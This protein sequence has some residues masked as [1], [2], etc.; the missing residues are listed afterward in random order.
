MAEGRAPIKI[1]TGYIE[2]TPKVLQK[3]IDELRKKLLGEMAKL[4]TSAGKEISKGVQEGIATLPKEVAK[5]AKK[6]K[7]AVEKE[8]LD[9]KK[10]LKRL[11]KELTK[12]FGEETAKRFKDFRKQELKKQKLI[13]ETS[14]ET[15]KAL[16]DAVRL[17]E[18]ANK[19][20]LTSAERLEK[21][22]LKLQEENRKAHE[23]A[24]RDKTKEEA[25]QLKLRESAEREARKRQAAAQREALRQQ[26][27]AQREATRQ[28]VA[29]IRRIAAADRAAA[30]D[31]I[32]AAQLR[33]TQLRDQMQTMRRQTATTTTTTQTYFRRT[34]TSLKNMGTWFDTVGTSISEAGNILT[35]KFLAPLALAGTALTALGVGNAD[36]RLLGQLGLSASGVSK[37][38][39]ADQMKAIQNYAIDTPFSIDV[40]HEYQMKLIRSVAGSDKDWFKGGDKRTNAANNAAVKTTD[41]IMSI[42]DSMARAGNLN[43]TQFQRAMYAMDMIMDMDRAPTRSVK[44]LAAASGMPASELANLLGFKDSQEMWKVIGTPAFQGTKTKK[45][46]VTGTEIMN[47]M[48]NF[49]NPD[50]YP[51][52]QTGDGS[53]GFASKMTSQTITGRLQQMKERS[54]FELGNLFVKEGKGGQYNYTDLGQK[55][56]GKQ[57]PVYGEDRK[58][59]Q[60]VTGYRNEGGILN[61]VTD[62]AKKYSPSIEKFLKLFLDSLSKFIKM[63]DSV[64]NFFKEHPVFT[65]LATSIGQFLVKW[66]PLIVAVGLLSKV[67]GKSIGLVGKLLSPAAA[68]TRGA[69]NAGRGTGRLVGQARAG[70]AARREALANGASRSDARQAGRDA[71]RDRRTQNRA[72]DTRG[73]GRRALDGFMGEDSNVRDQQRQLRELEAEFRQARDEATR[74]RTELRDINRESLRQIADAL[75]GNGANSVQGAANQAQQN[76]NQAQT[77]AQQLNRTNL[78][79]VGNAL[80]GVKDHADEVVKALKDAAAEVKTLDGRKLGS[81]R[82]QQVET[83]SKRVVEL[84]KAVNETSDAVHTLNGKSL[85]AL[86]DHFQQL[87]NAAK[88]STKE[89]KNANSAVNTLKSKS[90]KALRDWFDKVTKAA[91]E[92]YKKVGTRTGTGSLNGRVKSLADQS[93]KKLYDAVNKLA[94]NLEKAKKEAQS[95]DT[96]LD[97]IGKKSPG[98]SGSGGKKPK[99]RKPARGGIINANGLLTR[100]TGGVVPGYQPWVDS[101]PAILSP[102][103]AVLRP[104]VTNHLGEDQINAWNAM[105]VR[106]QLSRHARGGVAGGR[107]RFNLDS[108]KELVDLQNIY[109]VGISAFR[110]MSMDSA[111]DRLGGSSQ[112]GVLRTGDGTSRF[113]G[114]SAADK[115]R[116]MYDWMTEDIW[117]QLKKLPTVVGQVAGALAGAVSPVQGEYFWNDVWKGNGNILDR[118]KTYLGDMFSTKTLGKVWDNLTSGLWDSAKSLWD[119]GKGLLTDPVGMVSGAVGDVYD[120]VK[121][122]YNNLVGMV[123]TVKEFMDSPKDYAGRV[124]NEFMTTA[125]ESMPNTKG[126]FDFSSGSRVNTKSPDM[127]ATMASIPVKGGKGAEKWRLVASQAMSMLGLPP[128]ALSTVLYR[129]QMESGG[130]PNIVNKWDS[131]WKAGHPSVGLMQ[132]IGPTYGAYAG[133]FK[134]TGPKLYG[135]STNPLANIYAGLNYARNRY[136]ARWQSVLAGKT[137]YATGTMS[138][139]PGLA[140]VGEKGRELVAFGGGERVFNNTDTEGLLNGKKYEIHIHEARNEPTPQA[141]LRAL[142]TA[143]ALYTHL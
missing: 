92:A 17:E 131:N 1:G 25:R 121:G 59:N 123:D 15:K 67:L 132:V 35:T 133:P 32:A 37:Q 122:S 12:E 129:I 120:T 63:I 10:T 141:V 50:K 73:A 81:L 52:T 112:N 79:T 87:T 47:A 42:G 85:S 83:T 65:Q 102:G 115:F 40:M 117:T 70:S 108:I 5:Q 45:A 3:D 49:W 97:S 74:L 95:L 103:E 118:G 107:G 100:A 23:R 66:G 8:G 113:L 114:G 128:S 61:Q 140:M 88:E 124:F 60:V 21:N 41:L 127:D 89:I 134:G 33:M 143:E 18:K 72:G 20:R 104:E 43:P 96:S 71:Y 75:A 53:V 137:G 4:G 2:I 119:T 56:M 142:Q 86:R 28:Q 7:E 82:A 116:G 80:Q 109:P 44:Q 14:S 38:T 105:A 34:E 58:G 36:K 64:A 27:A 69:V 9:T 101:V 111:S 48:L 91:N 11:E 126:L 39:S 98:S 94:T 24:E 68:V 110:T 31:G 78:T 29:E 125:Q 77:Q 55:I 76:L 99:P 84:K 51:G 139:S 135:T 22:R 54:V 57:V 16:R 138:A 130:N 106:G 90:L 13:E 30:Q 6:A 93:L 62:M 136:G 26:V 46:G 19:D